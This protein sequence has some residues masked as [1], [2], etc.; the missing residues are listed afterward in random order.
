M[1]VR[2]TNR[3]SF[4]AGL[5]AAAALPM[6][7]R[8]QSR[9][10]IYRIGF[11]ADDPTIPSQPAGQ[12]FLDEP[13]ENGFVE[14]TNVVVERR[15]AEGI[16]ELYPSL[17]AELLRLDLDVLVTLGDRATVAAKWATNSL[18]IVMVNVDDPVGFD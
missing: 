14:G 18:P 11:L 4:I 9:D 8:G 16:L 5:G 12:A 1:F 6:A 7:A 2:G 17:V 10:K 13:R 15:Y 3:R